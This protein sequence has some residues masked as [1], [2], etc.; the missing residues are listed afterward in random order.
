MQSHKGLKLKVTQLEAIK[1]AEERSNAMLV[2][3][4]KLTEN[5]SVSG[6]K[7]KSKF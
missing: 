2:N 7:R 4:S 5:V 1:K 3:S 6:D